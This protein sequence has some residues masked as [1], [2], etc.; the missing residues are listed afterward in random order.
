MN[1]KER[2]QS[3]SNGELAIFLSGISGEVGYDLRGAV[4]FHDYVNHI[5]CDDKV[6]CPINHKRCLMND[7]VDDSCPY[8]PWQRIQYWLNLPADEK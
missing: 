3:M 1:Y 6:I 2:I 7:G 5:V 4:D 8:E